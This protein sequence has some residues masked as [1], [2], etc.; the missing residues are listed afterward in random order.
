VRAGGRDGPSGLCYPAGVMALLL[1]DISPLRPILAQRPFGLATDIDGTISPIVDRPDEAAVTDASRRHL[2]EIARHAAVVAVLTGRSTDDAR[3]VVGLDEL[4]YVGNHGLVWWENG[5]ERPLA[6]AAQY[7]GL[8][9]RA[10]EELA[11]TLDV[12]GLVLEDK[13]IAVAFHYRASPDPER[14][15]EAIVEALAPWVERG[16]RLRRGRMV[17]ELVRPVDVDKGTALARLMEAYHLRGVLFLGDDVT[18][19]DAFA[20]VRTWRDEGRVAGAAIAAANPESG[21]E[22]VEAADFWVDGVAGVEWLLGQ[23]ASVLGVRRP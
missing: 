18:D 6:E 1:E 5:E 15:R 19:L 23:V 12:P 20:A 7:A 13:G 4:T 22:V 11:S 10:K 16:L 9:H 17:L 14:A 21:S 2:W 3:R 8:V